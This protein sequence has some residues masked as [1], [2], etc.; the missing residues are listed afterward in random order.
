MN[1]TATILIGLGF[2]AGLMYLSD[3]EAGNRRRALIGGKL[4]RGL[5]EAG[6]AQT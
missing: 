6:E 1:P 5:R 2:G 4:R 3:P